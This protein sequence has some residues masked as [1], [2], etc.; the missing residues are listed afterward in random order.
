MATTT[1]PETPQV[2]DGEPVA[3]RKDQQPVDLPPS[4][5]WT[6]EQA[7]AAAAKLPFAEVAIIGFT[8]E[9]RI[10]VRHSRSDS[11]RLNWLADHLKDYARA[12]D[13]EDDGR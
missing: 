9:G 11:T 2:E 4:Q 7:L 12:E 13:F 8:N 3:K 5:T 10:V 1:E 6:P